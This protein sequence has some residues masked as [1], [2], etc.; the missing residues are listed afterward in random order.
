MVTW[1]YRLD[2]AYTLKSPH[3][4]GICFCNEWLRIGDGALTIPAGYAWDGCSPAWR[5]PGGLWLGTPDGPLGIDGRPPTFYPS[6][7]HDALCQFAADVPVTR[8]ATV[9][10]FHDMLRAAGMPAWCAALYAAAVRAFGPAAFGGDP[11]PAT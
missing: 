6:L 9:A 1:R 2:T 4:A 3:L 5:V 8:A 11:H 7:V 10:L